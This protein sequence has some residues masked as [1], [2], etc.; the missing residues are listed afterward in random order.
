MVGRRG[1]MAFELRLSGP[2]EGGGKGTW[3][4]GSRRRDVTEQG[5]GKGEGG[6]L[7]CSGMGSK[8]SVRLTKEGET[9]VEVRDATA[10]GKSIQ[11][12]G[13]ILA[14]TNKGTG[15]VFGKQGAGTSPGGGGGCRGVVLGRMG[16]RC[17]WH[18]SPKTKG[19][20]KKHTRLV[21]GG[22]GLSS[23]RPG[24]PHGGNTSRRLR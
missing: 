19:S 21:G 8:S 1:E 9:V 23:V 4:R 16:K 17:L 12:E 6:P 13:L 15:D 7:S 20:G 18:A 14:A 22:E 3:C 11:H 2:L 24:Q 10:E 5:S